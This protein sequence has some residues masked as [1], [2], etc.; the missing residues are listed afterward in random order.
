MRTGTDDD[1]WPP[2]DDPGPAWPAARWVLLAMWLAVVAYMTL[3]ASQPH[4][5]IDAFLRRVLRAITGH[6]SG[7]STT[8]GRWEELGNVALFVPLG[9]FVTLALRR[10][11]RWLAPV[12]CLAMSVAVEL[13]Q[14]VVVTT[15]H[16]SLQD[17]AENTLGGVIGWLLALPLIGHLRRRRRRRALAAAADAPTS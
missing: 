4:G 14:A 15:R 10:P 13:L 3:N 5:D 8:T 17:I 11:Q 1:E 6:D 9:L 16:A 2:E 12:I 7:A